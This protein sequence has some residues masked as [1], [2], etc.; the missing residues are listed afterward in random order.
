MVLLH[1][2][3]GLLYKSIYLSLHSQGGKALEQIDKKVVN[4]PSL[5]AFETGLDGVLGNPV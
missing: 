4:A 3:S 1:R 5:E 2:A